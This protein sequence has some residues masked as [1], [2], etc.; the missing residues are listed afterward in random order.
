MRAADDLIAQLRGNGAQ[1]FGCSPEEIESARQIYMREI[2]RILFHLLI[3][4]TAIPR[5]TGPLS[6]NRRWAGRLHAQRADTLDPRTGKGKTGPAWTLGAQMVEVEVD[7]S[8]YTYVSCR[9][10]GDR[11]GNV[12]NLTPC[13]LW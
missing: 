8:E 12:I 3:L 1:A 10:Y 7:V 5:L 6:A 11:L 4:S 2:R 13:A 9:E